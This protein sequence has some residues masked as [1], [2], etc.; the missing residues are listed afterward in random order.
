MSVWLDKQTDIF[1]LALCYKQGKN[2]IISSMK[3][4]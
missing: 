1:L 3:E 4:E 2:V